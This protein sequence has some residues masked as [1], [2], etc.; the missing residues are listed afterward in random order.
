MQCAGSAIQNAAMTGNEDRQLENVRRNNQFYR[1]QAREYGFQYLL[2]H[3]CSSCG[4]SDP[5]YLRLIMKKTKK[6]K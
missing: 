4:E 3:P 6:M 2:E 1:E 5:V